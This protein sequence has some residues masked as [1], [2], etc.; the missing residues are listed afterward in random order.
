MLIDSSAG[1]FR[2]R[3]KPGRLQEILAIA[4]SLLVERGFDSFTLDEVAIRSRCSKTTLYRRWSSKS[5]LIVDVIGNDI[6]VDEPNTGSLRGDI[7]Q[8]LSNI[9]DGMEHRDV[10]E[11]FIAVAL[12]MQKNEDLR[13]AWQSRGLL[14]GKQGMEKIVD[15]AIDRGEMKSRPNLSLLNCLLPGTFFWAWFVEE[16]VNREVFCQNL[17]QDVLLPFMQAADV[18]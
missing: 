5:D 12:A 18:E 17:L 11:M 10:G 6:V 16:S 2:S 15:R 3:M 7:E 9:A 1:E 8:L 13:R 4:R 14:P